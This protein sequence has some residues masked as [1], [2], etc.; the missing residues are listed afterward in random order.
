MLKCVEEVFSEVRV[1]VDD[2]GRMTDQSSIDDLGKL[3]K[4]EQDKL[5][6]VEELALL[7]KLQ[8]TSVKN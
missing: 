4:R 6:L 8:R 5:C 3:V 2:E 7:S 1:M